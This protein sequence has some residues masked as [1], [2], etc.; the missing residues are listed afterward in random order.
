[1]Q[2]ILYIIRHPVLS[3]IIGTGKEMLTTEH[4]GNR[5]KRKL[6]NTIKTCSL[7]IP[8]TEREGP[9]QPQIIFLLVIT[10]VYISIA[11]LY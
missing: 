11:E 9:W 8:K 10:C 4:W 5:S 1:M 3:V 7:I 6:D 2:V